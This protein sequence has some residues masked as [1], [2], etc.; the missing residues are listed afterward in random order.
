MQH[1]RDVAE[2]DA[3]LQ[4]QPQLLTILQALFFALYFYQEIFRINLTAV[5]TT[6]SF[7][8]KTILRIKIFYIHAYIHM[9]IFCSRRL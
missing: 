7:N 9:Y 8:Q 5:R 4:Y 2:V 3:H 1:D 6:I